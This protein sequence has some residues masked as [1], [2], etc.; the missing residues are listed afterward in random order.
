[1]SE[2]AQIIS[3]NIAGDVKCYWAM[4][5][6]CIIP[7]DPHSLSEELEVYKAW[8]EWCDAGMMIRNPLFQ[9]LLGY[10]IGTSTI[11]KDI[12]EELGDWQRACEIATV[13]A[14]RELAEE[15]GAE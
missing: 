1:M 8:L 13:N 3:Q 10:L 4:A 14:L 12:S 15:V 11:D 7:K 5:Y 2:N 9:G 6:H